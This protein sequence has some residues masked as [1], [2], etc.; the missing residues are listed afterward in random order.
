M[1]Q[2]VTVVSLL[3]VTVI[4]ILLISSTNLTTIQAATQAAVL[5][6]D[7]TTGADGGSCGTAS[8]PCKTIQGAVNVSVNGDTIR[9]AAGT[10]QDN[11]SC[12]D[13]VPAVVCLINRHLT[14]R[15]GYLSLIHI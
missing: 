8:Q 7:N 13:N 11:V 5:H 3:T 14:I 10:Y 4:A 15:G 6:V 2:K 12:L 9:V 1:K